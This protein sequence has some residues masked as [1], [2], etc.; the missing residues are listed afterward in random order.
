[1]KTSVT[2]VPVFVV[3]EVDVDVDVD[4][5]VGALLQDAIVR[6]HAIS[7]DAQNNSVDKENV[8]FTGLNIEARPLRSQRDLNVMSSCTVLSQDIGVI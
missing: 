3:V 8:D 5:A 1:M 6:P 2:T 4:G 7:G